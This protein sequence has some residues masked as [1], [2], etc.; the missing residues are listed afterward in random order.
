[1]SALLYTSFKSSLTNFSITRITARID[2]FKLDHHHPIQQLMSFLS[3]VG[4]F[5][6]TTFKDT[7]QYN[8]FHCLIECLHAFLQ[9]CTSFIGLLKSLE[10]K[11]DLF[12]VQLSN[13]CN[14][15][16]ND[17]CNSSSG[18]VAV[19][20]Q[21]DNMKESDQVKNEIADW[22]NNYCLFKIPLQ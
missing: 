16:N 3:I 18:L 15:N 8:L 20:S 5:L 12:S 22:F 19:C 21:G 1:M 13:S 4:F 2:Y 11:E 6:K 10:V 14:L 17:I 9:I 7:D